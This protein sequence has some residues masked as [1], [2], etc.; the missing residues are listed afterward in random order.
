MGGDMTKLVSFTVIRT[1]GREEP[2]HSE[3]PDMPLGSAEFF[4]H[5]RDLFRS[6]LGFGGILIQTDVQHK[7]ARRDMLLNS[8]ARIQREPIN[9]KASAIKR[10]PVYGDVILFN[11]QVW[12]KEPAQRRADSR[13]KPQWPKITRRFSSC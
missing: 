2:G 4:L 1:N 12:E 9:P 6:R 10:A 13:E 11:E 5:L 8:Y 7:G 3:F